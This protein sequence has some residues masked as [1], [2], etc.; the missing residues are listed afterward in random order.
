MSPRVSLLLMATLASLVS[1]SCS[2]GLD[3]WKLTQSSSL[4]AASD[5]PRISGI[6]DLG[7]L[8]VPG[9]GGIPRRT[10]DGVAVP[11]ETIL[12][13]GQGFGRLP[14]VLVGGIP[15]RVLGRTED[16]GILVRIPKGVEA[17]C[18]VLVTTV[19]GSAWKPLPF[20]R[21]LLTTDMNGTLSIR[22][23]TQKT[24]KVVSGPHLTG[25]TA[26][27]IH[28]FGALAY[29]LDKTGNLTVLDLAAASKPKVLDTLGNEAPTL[30]AAA[31]QADL[32]VT[33][34]R[35][36]VVLWDVS[37]PTRPSRWKVYKLPTTN[38]QISG[39]A[40][41]PDAKTLALATSHGLLLADVTDPMSLRWAS[42]RPHKV[43]DLALRGIRILQENPK[44]DNHRQTI[45]ILAGDDRGS[46]ALDDHGMQ[47]FSGSLHSAANGDDIPQARRLQKIEHVT[48]WTP[49][50]WAFTFRAQQVVSG[51]ALRQDPAR[52]LAYVPT[53]PTALLR[54]P[55]PYDS[56]A[57]MQTLMGMTNK[58]PGMLFLL[59]GTGAIRKNRPVPLLFAMAAATTGRRLWARGCILRPAKTASGKPT[60]VLACGLLVATGQG[61]DPRW[62]PDPE[63]R[64]VTRFDDCTRQKALAQP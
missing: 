15:T 23:V 36:K 20:R 35:G 13:R 50:T 53:I 42:E 63:T 12:I 43:T 57:A 14:T 40:L 24:P 1:I 41:S 44:A 38:S 55:R 59:D 61:T 16:G 10:G 28:R 5:T 17:P 37:H 58:T 54:I 29:L 64:P 8:L 21:Y 26:M 34:G 19:K 32:L 51:T 31:S 49:T 9:R 60:V 46:V 56:P 27:A 33:A 7:S 22:D 39:V 47:I 45:R 11:G 62:Y 48:T 2:Q 25:I 3:R 4:P 6:E 30:V 52:M 18:R